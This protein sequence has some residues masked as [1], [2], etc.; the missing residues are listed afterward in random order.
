[1]KKTEVKLQP[2]N[3][4]NCSAPVIQAGDTVLKAVNGFCYLDSLLT[5]AA[6]IDEDVS[7]RLAMV[8]AAFGGFTKCLWNDQGIRL[9]T[10]VAAYKAIVLTTARFSDPRVAHDQRRSKQ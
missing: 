1:M 9:T 6:N 8:S 4:Q 3:K 2:S 7:V 5:S 10:K